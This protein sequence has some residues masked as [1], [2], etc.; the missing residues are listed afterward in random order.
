[1]SQ[2]TENEV[3]EFEL[4]GMTC[5]HWFD[6]NGDLVV[7][8]PKEAQP[9]IEEFLEWSARQREE[10]HAVLLPGNYKPI[11]IDSLPIEQQAMLELLQEE[12]DK[13][14][15]AEP[16]DRCYTI[17][18]EMLAAKVQEKQRRNGPKKRV[19]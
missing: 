4:D 1:M 11:D 14:Q 13:V 5:F 3:V 15:D 16:Q 9:R 7:S 17:T 19:R 8:G 12:S 2:A 6:A 10:G 18:A